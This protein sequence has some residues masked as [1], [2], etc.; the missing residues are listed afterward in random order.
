MNI[1]FQTSPEVTLTTNIF[2]NVP[3]VLKYDGTP[4]IE[5]VKYEMF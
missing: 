5:I 3:V 4:L 1:Y 2:I